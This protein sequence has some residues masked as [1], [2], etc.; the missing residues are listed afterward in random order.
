MMELLQ[1]EA[2]LREIAGLIGMDAL[3]DP[4]RVLLECARTLREIVLTQ[5][6]Y[7]P[8]DASCTPEHTCHLAHAALEVYHNAQLA[9]QAGVTFD[10]LSLQ[11]ARGHCW[12][13]AAHHRSSARSG[14]L[15]S[16]GQSP[17]LHLQLPWRVQHEHTGAQLLRCARR[18]GSAAVPESGTFRR[19]R[20][21]GYGD[22]ARPA[23]PARTGPRSC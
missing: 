9:L 23:G 4:E 8:V 3:Q 5:S 22:G 6:A 13:C 16:T 12:L 7:D 18:S 1:R 11:P 10:Q 2:E 20:G 19:T 15:S 14:A 21:V 17:R